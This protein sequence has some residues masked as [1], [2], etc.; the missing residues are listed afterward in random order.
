MLRPIQR[1]GD[2][3]FLGCGQGNCSFLHARVIA[4]LTVSRKRF[5]ESLSRIITS[6]PKACS[7]IGQETGLY[8]TP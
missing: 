3:V 1:S 5:E 7:I 6:I 4:L 8:Q 2:L